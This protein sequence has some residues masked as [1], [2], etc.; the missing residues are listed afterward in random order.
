[1]KKLIKI[2]IFII[3]KIKII[4]NIIIIM[5]II[6]ITKITGKERENFISKIISIKKRIIMKYII[7]IN[8]CYFFR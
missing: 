8:F 7:E 2:I 5:G 6:N 3:I 1:M 4:V